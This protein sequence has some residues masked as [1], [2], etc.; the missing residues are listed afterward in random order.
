MLFSSAVLSFALAVTIQALLKEQSG[1]WEGVPSSVSIVIFFV[2]LCVVGLMEGM[3]IAAFALINMSDEELQTHKVAY[4]NCKLMFSGNLQAFLI[5]RQIFAAALMFIVAR[6]ATIDIPS[7]EENIFGVSNGFQNFLDTGLLGAVVLT[8]VG[9][10]VWRII[11]SSYPL[12]FMSNPA[13]FVI[14]KICFMLE[15][16]GICSSAWVLA[17]FHKVLVGYQP[18]EV[19]LDGAE[20]HG[21]EPVTRRDK[22]IDITVTVAKYSYSTA[23]L[24]FCIS[25]VMSALFSEKTTVAKN[26]HPVL[27]FLLFW[28]LICWLAMMEGGQGCLVGLQAIS[29]DVYASSHPRTL[30]NTIV[31]HE[32]DNMERFIIGRQFLVVLVIF[33]INTSASPIAEASALGFEGL[34]T[35]IFL[36]NGVAIMVT[37]IIL[38]QLTTQV[39]AAVCMLDFINNYFMLFTTCVSLG[40]EYSGL[41]HSVYLVQIGFSKLTGNPIVSKEVCAI[42][43]AFLFILYALHFFSN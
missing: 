28:F 29:R 8:I 25:F 27:A 2:L 10:L 20:K 13:I 12:A 1:M 7:G 23:I 11:A 30:T 16:T 42:V 37:T 21:S 14:I 17:R 3:Q 24:I 18:D 4:S 31:A 9:S 32:G 19:Y 26:V 40:I 35:S 34:V 41:L 22:D 36:D 43:V 6:I 38:G 15:K 33:L 5:G 39:N